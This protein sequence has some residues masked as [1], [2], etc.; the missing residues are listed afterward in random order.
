MDQEIKSRWL[1]K[2]REPGRKQGKNVLRSSDDFQCCLDL[3][4]EIAVEDGIIPA[5]E[6]LQDRYVYNVPPS[7]FHQFRESASGVLPVTVTRWA[8]LE[9]ENPPVFTGADFTLK[10]NHIIGEYYGESVRLS[11]LNDEL[12]QDFLKIADYIEGDKTL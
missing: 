1:S 10:L 11:Q 6:L 2:L 5:P 8:G 3:L 12:N 9:S 7:E 4:C